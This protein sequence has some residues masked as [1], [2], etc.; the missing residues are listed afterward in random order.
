M[1]CHTAG[2]VLL[3]SSLVGGRSALN[4]QSDTA[5]IIP[6]C[7]LSH[8]LSQYHVGGAF[9]QC[10]GPGFARSRH[11][12]HPLLFPTVGVTRDGDVY[13]S[14]TPSRDRIGHNYMQAVAQQSRNS[15]QTAEPLVRK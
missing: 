1:V 13:G 9:V 10:P 7:L 14:A 2:A 15:R 6:P 12:V 4:P 3:V 11:M 8:G 5:E